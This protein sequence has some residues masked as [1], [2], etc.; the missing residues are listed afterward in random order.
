MDKPPT[1]D[2]LRK[3][4]GTPI[5]Q[6]KCVVE[7]Q[8]EGD[9]IIMFPDGTVSSAQTKKI[10]ERACRAWFTNNLK[11]RSKVQAAIGLIEWRT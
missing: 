8:P 7:A 4:I 11:E 1:I 3:L 2:D 10:A 6:G 5:H 9:W